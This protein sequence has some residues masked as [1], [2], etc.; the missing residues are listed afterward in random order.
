MMQN[1]P[2]N[3][4]NAAQL[5]ELALRLLGRPF[6]PQAQLFA[7]TL[8]PSLP[9]P[10]P[11]P[12]ASQLVGSF[13]STAEETQIVLD[14]E[15]TPD[16]VMAFYSEQMQAMG[17]A[18]PDVLRRLRQREGGF[19]H[20]FP[21]PVSS[22]TFCQGRHGPALGVSA[23]AGQN[24][25][26]TTD[27]RLHLDTRTR[28]SPCLQSSEIFMAV[29]ALLPSLEPPSGASQQVFGGGSNSESASTAATLT[30]ERDLAL[31]ELAT[32]YAEQLEQAGWQRTGE[33]SSGPQAWNTWQLRDPD[34][35]RWVGVFTL[36][37]IPETQRQYAL[38]VHIYWT[39]E[40]KPE[41]SV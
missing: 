23:M 13:V 4:E 24:D 16:E 10:I 5:R 29:G 21:Y 15:Q 8:P 27:V 35:E 39:G 40:T 38:Q 1:T 26:A 17:W 18:E 31:A 19:T 36:L 37:Q 30:M 11:F 7:G 33:G 28:N 20:T 9:F 25:R 14:T 2:A 6:V 3:E 22:V 41:A 34:Q 12:D 32:H